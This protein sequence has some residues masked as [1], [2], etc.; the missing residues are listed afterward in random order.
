MQTL[1]FLP[2]AKQPRKAREVLD[3]FLPVAD[4]L[5]MPALNLVILVSA[6]LWPDTTPASQIR[7]AGTA[8]ATGHTASRLITVQVAGHE[9]QGWICT[10]AQTA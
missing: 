6:G 2:Q 3:T 10:S 8:G 7:A 5:S 4:Q 1:Q 9:H